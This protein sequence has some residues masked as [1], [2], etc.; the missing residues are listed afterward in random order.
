MLKTFTEEVAISKLH[1]HNDLLSTT[2]PFL[3]DYLLQVPEPAMSKLGVPLVKA[4]KLV[5]RLRSVEADS[6]GPAT[7]NLLARLVARNSS[8]PTG[9]G[10]GASGGGDGGGG[11][12]GNSSGGHPSSPSQQ[13]PPSL[14]LKEESE[15]RSPTG[16][17]GSQVDLKVVLEELAIGHLEEAVV[18]AA[19]GRDLADLVR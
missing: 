12:G 6:L 7:S 9:S 13:E 8:N 3:D 11:S 16:R 2:L 17:R 4:R 10:T 14:L 19:G 5:D 18:V 1:I 15:V